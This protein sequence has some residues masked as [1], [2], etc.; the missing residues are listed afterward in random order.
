MA[1]N[2]FL[3]ETDLIGQNDDLDFM[4]YSNIRQEG[5]EFLLNVFW[6]FSFIHPPSAVYYPGEDLVNIRLRSTAPQ[7]PLGITDLSVVL[8]QFTSAQTVASG[9]TSGTVTLSMTDFEDQPLLAWFFDW[10]DKLGSYKH[11]FIFRKEDTT[12]EGKLVMYN[13]SRKPIREYRLYSLQPTDIGNGLNPTFGSGDPE[14]VGDFDVTLRFEHIDL[15]WR[16]I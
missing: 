10:R 6:R 13:T 8:R 15:I 2:R 5:K 4:D 14:Q 7:I 12:A 1:D 16:N 9:T 11:R 3:D